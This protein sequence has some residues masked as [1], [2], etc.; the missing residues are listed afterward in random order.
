METPINYTNELSL[1]VYQKIGEQ[2]LRGLLLEGK[3][4]M[5]SD[6]LIQHITENIGDYLSAEE[7]QQ[8]YTNNLHQC[9][10]EEIK[11]LILKVTIEVAA[12]FVELAFE[13]TL[14]DEHFVKDNP[15]EIRKNPL[16]FMM[17]RYYDENFG[18]KLS[19]D[20]AGRIGPF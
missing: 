18:V 3:A 1:R 20:E 4:L 2:Q 8:L 16:L 9:Q 12:S 19:K 10:D 15:F 5:T 14:L 7:E 11:S 17:Y 13:K 6:E